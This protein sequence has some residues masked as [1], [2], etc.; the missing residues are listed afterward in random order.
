MALVDPKVTR[1]K[2]ERELELWRE[3]EAAYRERGWVLLRHE[4]VQLDIGFLA[5]LGLAGV[6]VPVMRACFR[7]DYSD[8]D[9]NPPSV[10]FIDAFRG[11]YAPPPVPAV[12]PTP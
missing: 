5:R 3:N 12:V 1:R 2:L 6:Q 7:L 4:D 10:E 11:E 9:L 8:Y